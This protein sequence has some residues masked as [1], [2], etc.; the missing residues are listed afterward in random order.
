M[1][2]KV[3]VFDFDGVITRRGEALKEEAWEMLV[4]QCENDEV[5]FKEKFSDILKKNR[6]R[7]GQGKAKGSREDIL[8]DTF[9]EL[10]YENFFL[11]TKICAYASLYNKIVQDLIQNDGISEDTRSALR[12]YSQTLPLY[13]NSA[14]P[15]YAV[16]ESVKNLE[17]SSFF[18]EVLGQPMSKISN[19]QYVLKNE[20]VEP[21]ALL[22]VGDGKGDAEA[23]EAIKCSFVG[24]SNDWNCWTK[25]NVEF[26]LVK[27]IKNIDKF[28]I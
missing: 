8:R 21:S 6:A 24:V 3:I 17:L 22:F 26:P 9:L 19:L 14:T 28:L 16:V 25:E 7:Y 20:N 5:E 2:I 4:S 13:I 12:L 10:G 15:Q 27:N 23:A 18:K 11:Q 1:K